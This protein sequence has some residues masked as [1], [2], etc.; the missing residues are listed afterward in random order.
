VIP[1]KRTGL[2]ALLNSA[3]HLLERI[4]ALT[5]KVTSLL[6]DN[7]QKSLSHI[8][9]NTD[10]L[11]GEMARTA[12]DLRATIVETR[13]TVKQAAAAADSFAQLAAS[14][15]NV[16]N[17][18]GKPMIADLR[19]A[20][21]QAEHSLATLDATVRESQPGV[22]AFTTQTLP[23]MSLLVRDLRAMSDSLGSVAKK[24]DQ[25]GAG[26]LLGSSKLP[27]YKPGSSAK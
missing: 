20:V 6:N 19:A 7:N 4:S 1:A 5:E 12:P 16:M 11:T 8:L 2:G 21:K 24:V 23:E 25:G 13:A 15:N 18:D 9:A 26:A 27:D 14:A 3:P 22:K 17:E 10:K